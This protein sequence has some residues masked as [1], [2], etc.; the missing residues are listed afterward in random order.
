[1]DIIKAMESLSCKRGIFHSE[2]DFQFALAWEIKGLYPDCSVRLEVPFRIRMKG[3]IDI[4]VRLDDD[5]YPIEVK[6]I[7][8][9]FRY[10]DGNDHYDL[11]NGVHDLDMYNCMVDIMRMENFAEQLAGFYTGYVIWLTNDSAYWISKYK[12]TYYREFHA[13]DGSVKTGTMR[14]LSS[15]PKTG[16]PPQI[17]E[18]KGY[19]SPISLKDSYLIRWR[20]YSDLAVPKGLFKYAV[21][22]I[23]SQ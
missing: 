16:K 14:F 18:M 20:L 10:S 7:K 23:T 15:N 4:L 17:L 22:P 9:T 5:I 21:I 3:R 1:M 19:Q 11:V 13:P 8:K 12:S 6:Y 2:A